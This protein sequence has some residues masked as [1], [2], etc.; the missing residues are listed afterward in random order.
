[1][2]VTGS[3]ATVSVDAASE[4][5]FVADY[6]DFYNPNGGSA[7]YWGGVRYVLPA[8]WAAGTGH[9]SHS[10]SIS[11]RWFNPSV[12]DFHP[13]SA[14][15]RY[16]PSS[17]G[18]VNDA[19]TSLTIDAADPAEDYSLEPA[20]NGGRANLGSYGDTPKASKTIAGPCALTLVPVPTASRSRTFR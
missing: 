6:N 1:V 18:F 12:E 5:G 16:D 11:P 19:V 17:G 3:S 2:N 8:E 15:G 7:G 13:K 20:P 4:A 14:A 9:D 10:I